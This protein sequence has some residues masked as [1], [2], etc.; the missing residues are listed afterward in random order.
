M[1]QFLGVYVCACF[2]HAYAYSKCAHA[3][4]WDAHEH[5]CP[6]TQFL[7]LFVFFHMFSLCFLLPSPRVCVKDTQ[8]FQKKKQWINPTLENECELKKF[9]TFTVYLRVTPFWTY[10]TISFFKTFSP[11]L[12]CVCV[13]NTQYSQK[14][15]Q[16]VNPTLENECELKRFK[17]RAMY[18]R[19][20]PFWI[21]TTI[22]FF[23]TFF[24]LPMCV[25]GKNT[26]YSK[27][28]KFSLCLVCFSHV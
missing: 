1:G 21:Y 28:K 5:L 24:H 6:E 10:I 8:Y 9:K 23:K 16:W 3:Y 27:K 15:K 20:R 14:K 7:V 17:T 19:F 13:K 4:N 2:M 12:V 25:C 22:S 11:L 26:Q 18:P